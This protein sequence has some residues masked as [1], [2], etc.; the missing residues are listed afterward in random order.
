MGLLNGWSAWLK[1]NRSWFEVLA[2]LSN[3]N[4][5]ELLTQFLPQTFPMSLRPQRPVK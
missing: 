2:M 1:I 5:D 3:R 4:E